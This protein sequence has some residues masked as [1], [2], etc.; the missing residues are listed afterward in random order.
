MA[1]GRDHPAAPGLVY[2]NQGAFYAQRGFVTVVADY[3]LL[4]IAG[5]TSEGAAGDL[6]GGANAARY[7]SG[8]EDL[9]Y[10]LEWVKAELP[11]LIPEADT[12]RLYAIGNSAGAFHVLSYLLDPA[13]Q[14]A[15]STPKLTKAVSLAGPL[16][17]THADPAR[18]PILLGYLGDEHGKIQHSPA[19][20]LAALSHEQV[21]QLPPVLFLDSPFDPDEIRLAHQTFIKNWHAKGGKGG[22]EETPEDH[23]HISVGLSPCSGEGEAYAERIAEWLNEKDNL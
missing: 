3:R 23:N 10:V 9:Q 6:S 7:P 1:G 13:F 14:L 12:T 17:F 20:N 4:P 5:G 16:D 11:K 19:Q 2:G 8:A 18:M 22:Y 21:A 15:N